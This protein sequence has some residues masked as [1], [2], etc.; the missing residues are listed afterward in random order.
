MT[1]D[2]HNAQRDAVR[3]SLL[4]QAHRETHDDVYGR[5]R[6]RLS[7]DPISVRSTCESIEALGVLLAAAESAEARS[8]LVLRLRNRLDALDAIEGRS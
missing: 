3:A 5:R 1:V 4:V 7:Q 2:Q 8:W 6:P